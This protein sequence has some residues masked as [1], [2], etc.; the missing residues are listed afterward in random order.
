MNT[1]INK[2]YQ[3]KKGGDLSSQDCHRINAELSIMKAEDIPNEQRQNV[4][5]YLIAALNCQ[6]VQPLLVRQLDVLLQEL[7]ENA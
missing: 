6:S 5:D 4:V 1:L 3:V 2:L 7:Q